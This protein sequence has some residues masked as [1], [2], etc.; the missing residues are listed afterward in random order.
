MALALATNQWIWLTNAIEDLIV[1]VTNAAMFYNIKSAIDIAYNHKIG[2]R[3]KHID[4]AY[5]LVHENI[6][7]GR[8][9]LLQIESDE[10]LADICPK[11]LQQVTLRKL[12][13]A[14]IDAIRG[15]ILDFGGY[16]LTLLYIADSHFTFHNF[17]ILYATHV[18]DSGGILCFCLYIPT[19]SNY[20]DPHTIITIFPMFWLYFMGFPYRWICISCVRFSPLTFVLFYLLYF[21][22]Y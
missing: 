13:T 20:V 10:N 16:F 12:G 22:Y 21:L 14:I 1:P 2:D 8:I 3:S 9:S 5:H 11:G 19:I 15:G 17:F 6:E 4:V 18:L 7:S